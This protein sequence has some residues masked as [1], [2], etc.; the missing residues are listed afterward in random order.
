[1][2]T[3]TP[4]HHRPLWRRALAAIVACT[5]AAAI[6]LMA[7]GAMGTDASAEPRENSFLISDYGQKSFLISSESGPTR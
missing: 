6:A 1:M 7:I 2:T 5:M 3:S 4:S